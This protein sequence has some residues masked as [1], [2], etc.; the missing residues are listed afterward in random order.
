MPFFKKVLMRRNFVCLEIFFHIEKPDSCK[1]CCK[2]T[3][4]E[5]SKESQFARWREFMCQFTVYERFSLSFSLSILYIYIYIYICIYSF[6]NSP[7]N[8]YLYMYKGDYKYIFTVHWRFLRFEILLLQRNVS[9]NF[10]II[11]D[12]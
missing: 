12:I 5:V 3:K 1:F 6:I 9:L 10:Y 2:N 11:F 4:L 8:I 7:M